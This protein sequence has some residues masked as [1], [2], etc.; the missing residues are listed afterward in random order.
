MPVSKHIKKGLT[1]RQW[2]KRRNIRRANEADSQRA[3]IRGR[4]R[5]A[6]VM[7]TELEKKELEKVKTKG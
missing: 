6:Q 7:A 3:G 2:R 4:I 5:A 1:A